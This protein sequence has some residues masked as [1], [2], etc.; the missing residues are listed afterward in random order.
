MP[1]E[2]HNIGTAGTA[3]RELIRCGVTPRVII[4]L[5]V[6]NTTTSVRKYTIRHVP[7]DETPDDKFCL[8]KDVSI[9]ANSTATI[10]SP[11]FLTDG[12]VID[13]SS[14]AASAVVATAYTIPASDYYASRS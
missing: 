8:F 2:H 3:A 14:D 9:R 13:I 10:D 6:A 4:S 1:A 7:A 11:V 12:D 5:I